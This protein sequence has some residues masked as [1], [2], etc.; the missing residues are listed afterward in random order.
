MK[1]LKRF[2]KREQIPQVQAKPGVGRIQLVQDGVVL[3]DVTLTRVWTGSTEGTTAL[4]R[5]TAFL[6]KQRREG[7]RLPGKMTAEEYA[8][9]KDQPRGWKP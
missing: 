2:Q 7:G 4:F 1:W 5:D 9:L 3:A 8:A 6:E